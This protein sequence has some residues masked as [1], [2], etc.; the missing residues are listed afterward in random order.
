MGPL[1]R[2]GFLSMFDLLFSGREIA[3]A[4]VLGGDRYRTAPPRYSILFYVHTLLSR[5]A[6]LRDTIGARHPVS[7]TPTPRNNSLHSS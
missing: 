7:E 3:A 1:M 4:A 5:L 2:Y 6:T